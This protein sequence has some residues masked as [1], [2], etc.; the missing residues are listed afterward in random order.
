MSTKAIIR[1]VLAS[2]A[3]LAVIPVQD[4]LG[5]GADTRINIP[6]TPEGNWRFRMQYELMHTVDRDYF[7]DMNNTY[8]RLGGGRA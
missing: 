8:G 2:A 6:G 4:M 3:V 7:L 5:Y 1:T